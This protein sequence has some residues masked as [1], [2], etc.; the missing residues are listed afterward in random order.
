MNSKVIAYIKKKL[1]DYNLVLVK[2]IHSHLRLKEVVAIYR[3]WYGLGIITSN[4][5]INTGVSWFQLLSIQYKVL[6][7]IK[8]KKGEVNITIT[9]N[10]IPFYLLN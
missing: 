6:V 9:G 4:K 1:K 3:S 7:N 10:I 8:T 2:V 5:E